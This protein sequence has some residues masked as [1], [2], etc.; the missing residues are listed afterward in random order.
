MKI[1]EIKQVLSKVE[2]GDRLRVTF[3]DGDLGGDLS[4]YLNKF[5]GHVDES[6]SINEASQK[7]L[8]QVAAKCDWTDHVRGCIVTVCEGFSAETFDS[9]IDHG[10]FEKIEEF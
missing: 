4:I 5:L 3:T 10:L 2:T 9:M 1:N 8:E 7:W 6:I